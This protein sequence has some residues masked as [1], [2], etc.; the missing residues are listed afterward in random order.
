MM[1]RDKLSISCERWCTTPNQV[2]R[3]RRPTIAAERAR[4]EDCKADWVI[5]NG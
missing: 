2:S 4:L 3:E 1:A 5:G